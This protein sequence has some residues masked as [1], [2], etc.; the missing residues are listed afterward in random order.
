M[1]AYAKGFEP[2]HTGVQLLIPPALNL[3]TPWAWGSKEP[4]N[5]KMS[6][7]GGVKPET[8]RTVLPSPVFLDT[9]VL[10][11]RFTNVSRLCPLRLI[12]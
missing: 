10:D 4:S 2:S 5:L 9:L 8:L 3:I 7:G 12:M 6:P 11:F 1:L